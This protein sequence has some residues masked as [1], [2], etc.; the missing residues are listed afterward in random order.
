MS[1]EAMNKLADNYTLSNGLINYLLLFRNFLNGLT[2]KTSSSTTSLATSLDL[3]SSTQNLT[4][5]KSHDSGPIHPWEFGYKRE[6]KSE[7]PYWQQATSVPKEQEAN[8]ALLTLSTFKPQHSGAF[9]DKEMEHFNPKEKEILLSQY[10]SSV[11]ELCNKVYQMLARNWRDVRAQFKKQQI[12]NDRGS[13]LATHFVTILEQNGIN[14]TKKE[15]GVIVKTFRVNS[16][17]QD[18]VKF[19]EFLRV[20]LMTKS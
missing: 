1:A 13:I 2:N 4:L 7:H 20:C 15:L 16:T 8:Q 6:R 5:T 9:S 18:M 19:D 10:Q 17:S 12:N 3:S 14:L 11:V